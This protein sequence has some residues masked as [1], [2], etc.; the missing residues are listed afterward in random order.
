MRLETWLRFTAAVAMVAASPAFAQSP[1]TPRVVEGA[2]AAYGDYQNEVSDI[3]AKPL[4]NADHLDRALNTFGAQNANQL[5]AGWISYTALIASQN[6]EF[7][8]SVRD[9]DAAYGRER[10]VNGLV[11][12]PAYARTLKGGE[13]ALQTA[14]AANAR[15][16]GRFSSAAAFVKEQAYK[17]QN[18]K[19]AKSVLTRGMAGSTA[20]GLKST[21][22]SSR[23]IGDSALKMFSGPDMNLMLASA[24]GSETSVWD[25]IASVTT[26]ASSKAISAISPIPSQTLNIAPEREPTAGRIA[27]TAALRALDADQTHTEQ[28]KASMNDKVTAECIDVSQMQMRGCVSA[29]HTKGELSFCLAEQ[30]RDS[31]ACFSKVTK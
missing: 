31:G 8:A 24:Q 10:V 13:Q 4:A 5:S 21:S 17:L 2:A 12:D 18:V 26:G 29:A 3:R 22:Q 14:L 23:P 16:T 1:S 30:I 19:W 11:L 20:E 6:K 27:A 15:D 7:A 28:V 25:K 9:I